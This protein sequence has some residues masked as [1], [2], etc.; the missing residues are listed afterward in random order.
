MCIILLRFV[1]KIFQKYGHKHGKCQ[2]K[3]LVFLES[4]NNVYFNVLNLG[5]LFKSMINSY[6]FFDFI[7]Y[8]WKRKCFNMHLN[9]YIWNASRESTCYNSAKL[10]YKYMKVQHQL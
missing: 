1:W 7:A 2:L 3:T 5:I 10:N 8:Y 4:I 9:I 6:N